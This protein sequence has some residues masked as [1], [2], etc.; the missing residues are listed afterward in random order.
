M[1]AR[2]QRGSDDVL[3]TLEVVSVC[4]ETPCKHCFDAWGIVECLVLTPALVFDI[5]SSW[6]QRSRADGA[7]SNDVLKPL[8][9]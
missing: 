5:G 7:R 4:R 6:R 2:R 8:I 9:M 3:K 1:A